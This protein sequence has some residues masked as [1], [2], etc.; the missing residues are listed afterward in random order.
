M[1]EAGAV[2]LATP[3]LR[4]EEEGVDEGAVPVADGGVDD[5][6]R[7]L[8]EDEEVLVLEEDREGDVLRDQLRLRERG[9][10]EDGVDEVA[11]RDL[12]GGLRDGAAR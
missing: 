6:A 9:R 8:V 10:R 2:G 5:E 4:V 7:G 1:D 3:F 12:R 11:G